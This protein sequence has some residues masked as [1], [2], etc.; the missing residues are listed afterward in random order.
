M[1]CSQWKSSVLK[2][3]TSSLCLSLS[4]TLWHCDNDNV[5]TRRWCFRSEN[6]PGAT[7]PFVFIWGKCEEINRLRDLQTRKFYVLVS[8]KERERGVREASSPRWSDRP[9]LHLGC[10]QI[11]KSVKTIFV[12]QILQINIRNGP[13]PILSPAIETFRLTEGVLGCGERRGEAELPRV[14][15]NSMFSAPICLSFYKINFTFQYLLQIFWKQKVLRHS[16]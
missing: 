5:I 11:I 12:L 3:A 10:L 4:V 16:W 15:W 6:H 13:K 9:D 7:R 2:H 8:N 14:K 1:A